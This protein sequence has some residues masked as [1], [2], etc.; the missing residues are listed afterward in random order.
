MR[1]PFGPKVLDLVWDVVA[2]VI[3]VRA[4]H[5]AGGLPGQNG[6]YDTPYPASL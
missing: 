6:W 2:A 1:W 4:P 3:V 5:A